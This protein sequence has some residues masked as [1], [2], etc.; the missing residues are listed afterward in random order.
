MSTKNIFME[1]MVGAT[2]IASLGSA[3]V[4]S[5]NFIDVANAADNT[6]AIT[7]AAA[8]YNKSKSKSWNNYAYGN[9]LGKITY[10]SQGVSIGYQLP[11]GF[12]ALTG[13]VGI[14]VRGGQRINGYS[15]QEDGSSFITSDY[16][17]IDAPSKTAYS[18]MGGQYAAAGQ[19]T[20][21]KFNAITVTANGSRL[22]FDGND[23]A[24]TTRVGIENLKLSNVPAGAKVKTHYSVAKMTGQPTD[25]VKDADTVEYIVELEGYFKAFIVTTGDKA[26][27]NLTRFDKTMAL[28]KSTLDKGKPVNVT[29]S[30]WSALKTGYTENTNVGVYRNFAPQYFIDYQTNHL[31][32]LLTAVGADVDSAPDQT[33]VDKT[34]LDALIIKA[35]SEYKVG[36]GK[37]TEESWNVFDSA[38]K[39]AEGVKRDENS[40]QDQ[41]DA[42]YKALNDAYNALKARLDT[43]PVYTLGDLRDVKMIV[44]G[45]EVA[46]PHQGTLKVNKTAVVE[47]AGVPEGWAVDKTE[48]GNLVTFKVSSPDGKVSTKYVFE[49]TDSATGTDTPY[50]NGDTNNDS[51]NQN[52]GNNNAGNKTNTNNGFNNANRP[53]V[54]DQSGD[55]AKTGAGIVTVFAAFAAIVSG[56]AL[57]MSSRI[58]RNKED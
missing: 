13:P 44:D 30:A 33:V 42:A 54:P 24:K 38:Y 40:T 2:T 39:S 31:E 50:N 51:T 43:T 36:V 5:A 28:A 9:Q 49:R 22:T 4:V 14:P 16:V 20:Q 52:N 10:N 32:D 29:D 53:K 23:T 15:F 56:G 55:L 58:K 1:I 12:K 47:L 57:A 3:G 21:D 45:N 34:R 19:S 37:Y 27:T 48:E 26:D 8:F 17:T 25:S 11:Y 6:T 35:A 18:I 7:R 46:M 41:M